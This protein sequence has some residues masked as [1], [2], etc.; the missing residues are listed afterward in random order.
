MKIGCLGDIVFEVSDKEMKTIRDATWSGSA[1][2]ATHQRHLDNALQEFVGVDPDSF[3]F[4]IRISQFLGSDPL[5]DISKLF[6]YER[7]GTAVPLTIGKKGYGKYR[8]L[9]K[10]HKTSLEHYDKVG[11]LV[12]VDITVT[13]TEYTKG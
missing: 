13:L 11:N 9:V 2:I 5:T 7:G 4:K 10:K 8:W 3:E 1:S 12:G 6:D